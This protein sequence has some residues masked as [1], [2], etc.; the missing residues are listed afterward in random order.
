MILLELRKRGVEVGEKSNKQAD[1]D[2]RWAD[3][4]PAR[5]GMMR[6]LKGPTIEMGRLL[7]A[8]TQGFVAGCRVSQ[9]TALRLGRMVRVP[10]G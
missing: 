5:G 1:K 2:Q 3:K 9:W 6:M 8:G 4:L 10:G 7:S